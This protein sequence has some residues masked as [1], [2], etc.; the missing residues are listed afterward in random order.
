MNRY[1]MIKLVLIFSLSNCMIGT[2]KQACMYYVERD[3]GNSCL[4]LAIGAQL[5]EADAPLRSIGINYF[6]VNCFTY[7]KKKKDCKKEENNYLPGLYGANNFIDKL[8][9]FQLFQRKK[10]NRIS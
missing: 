7:L 9:H 1:Q 3:Y 2:Q 5:G 4:S 10:Q 8:N 6:L